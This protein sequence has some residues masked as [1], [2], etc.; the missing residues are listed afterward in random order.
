MKRFSVL[1]AL[2]MLVALGSYAVFAQQQQASPPPSQQSQQPM[3]GGM[4]GGG[5][6]MRGGGMMGGG[7]GPG[8]MQ[9]GMMGRGMGRGMMMQQGAG[10]PGCGAALGALM[11]ESITATSDGGVVVAV[12]GKLIKYD[13]ALKKVAETN[14][15]IDWAQVHQ[16]MQQILQNCPMA[17]QQQQTAQQPPTWQGQLPQ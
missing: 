11:H 7:M 6:M 9:G 8:M 1:A 4:M 14:V 13:G 12:A 10:C 3:G 17:R 5:G 15:D 2:V 16:R